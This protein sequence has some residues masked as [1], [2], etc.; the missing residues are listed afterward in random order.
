[1]LFQSP[2]RNKKPAADSRSV[3]RPAAN[4]SRV[5]RTAPEHGK[6]PSAP[7]NTTIYVIGDVHG[8][9]GLLED[10]HRRLDRDQARQGKTSAVEI[11][12]GDYIDRGENSAKVISELLKRAATRKIV[13]LRGN[14]ENMLL[15]FMREPASLEAWLRLGGGAT[16]ASYGVKLGRSSDRHPRGIQTDLIA[17]MPADHF[18]FFEALPSKLELGDYFFAH[19]GVRPSISLSAQTDEDLTTI[20]T[21]FL[22]H[23]NSFGRIV[24]HGHTPVLTPEFYSNRINIDTGAFATGSLTCLKIDGYGPQILP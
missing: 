14:H 22:D 16:L 18:R 10:L 6:Y 9:S 21:P 24:V 7:D 23:T 8:C 12:L 5:S 4:G 13:C 20:R 3:G 11:Y 17:R 1:M 19:A 15:S 2:A